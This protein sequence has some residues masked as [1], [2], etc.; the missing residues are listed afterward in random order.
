MLRIMFR[1]RMPLQARRSAILR[2]VLA[3]SS[4][5]YEATNANA[6]GKIYYGSRVGMS[7]TVVTMNGLDTSRAVIHTKH[8]RDDAV[9][10]CRD[11]VGEVTEEC[12]QGELE[13]PLNDVISGNCQTGVFTDF[14]GTQYQ[15]KGEN[16]EADAMAKYVLVDLSNGKIADGSSASGYPVNMRLF[17][18]LCPK[19]APFDIE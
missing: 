5:C 18:A 2:F 11:Y 14:Y 13:T 10:F 6:G 16:P 8:T 17:R 19:T 15:F 1:Q 9:A 3:L 12:V 7:V 4:V